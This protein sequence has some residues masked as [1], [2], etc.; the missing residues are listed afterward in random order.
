MPD[1][2]VQLYLAASLDGYLARPDGSV[3][4][5][6]PFQGADYGPYAY[7]A[8]YAGVGSLVMGR[9]TYEQARGSGPWPYSGKPTAVLTRDYV[10]FPPPPPEVVFRRDDP[11]A[12]CSDLMSQAPGHVWLVGGGR[13]ARSFLDAELVDRIIL[14]VMPLLLGDGIPLFLSSEQ[15]AALQLRDSRHFENGVVLLDYQV[16]R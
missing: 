6:K 9:H 3:D 5:L 4:W 8:F 7:E 13:V 12:V 10:L 15:G 1:Q 14:H 2:E 11:A 16:R